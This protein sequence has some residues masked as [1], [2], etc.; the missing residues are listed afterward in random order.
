MKLTLEKHIQIDNKITY[1]VW[2]DSETSLP[3]VLSKKTE[4][5]EDGLKH[6]YDTKERYKFP[7]I[8]IIKEIKL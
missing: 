3:R 5:L 6:L 7:K 8:E 4:F 1:Y 2:F